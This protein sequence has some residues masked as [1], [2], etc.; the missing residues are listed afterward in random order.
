MQREHTNHKTIFKDFEKPTEINFP[1]FY[2]SMRIQNSLR[3]SIHTHTDT[4]TH[5]HTH[6]HTHI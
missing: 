4:H 5:T 6:A 3:I 1:L 2:Q